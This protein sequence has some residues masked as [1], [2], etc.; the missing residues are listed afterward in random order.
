V[1]SVI[2]QSLHQ[3]QQQMKQIETKT[4]TD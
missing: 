3:P 4:K 1:S 2:Y